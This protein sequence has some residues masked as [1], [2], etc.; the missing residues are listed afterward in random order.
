MINVATM[1]PIAITM[2]SVKTVDVAE[3][4]VI[5]FSGLGIPREIL[6]DHGSQFTSDLTKQINRLLS[7]KPITTTPY[8]AM[9]KTVFTPVPA[10]FHSFV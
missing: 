6:S 5:I 10:P 2:T 7:I 9:C 8:H 1:Y 4:L 3:A